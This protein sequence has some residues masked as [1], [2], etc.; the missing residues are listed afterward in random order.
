MNN[1]TNYKRA[2]DENETDKSLN[3]HVSTMKKE[4][5]SLDAEA[6]IAP[7]SKLGKTEEEKLIGIF[8]KLV[9][10]TLSLNA[11]VS[12]IKKNEIK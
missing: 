12:I 8:G 6:P 3:I 4:I 10:P 1:Q 7:Q 2:I 11:K 9:I 5:F